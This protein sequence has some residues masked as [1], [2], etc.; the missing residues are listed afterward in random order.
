MKK[1]IA[2]N[3]DLKKERRFFAELLDVT[4]EKYRNALLTKDKFPV[5]LINAAKYYKHIKTVCELL[6]L[7]PYELYRIRNIGDIRFENSVKSLISYCENYEGEQV[8]AKPADFKTGRLLCAMRCI[9]NEEPL[10]C[11][12][13][14]ERE[15]RHLHDF[16]FA[17]EILPHDL[18][19]Y[20]LSEAAEL[21]QLK[22]TIITLYK[23][24]GRL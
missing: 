4:P 18:L 23:K 6:Y 12:D 13:F 3:D 14:D 21:L 11:F 17:A 16:K 15:R 20:E 1:D 2:I 9:L 8:Q 19:E 7:S 10:P 24:I 22:R 5:T